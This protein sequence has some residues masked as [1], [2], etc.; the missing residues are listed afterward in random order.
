MKRLE[1]F[2][3]EY[4]R[5]YADT[6]SREREHAYRTALENLVSSLLTDFGDEYKFLQ[7]ARA[8]MKRQRPDFI[9]KKNDNLI[10]ILE[11][12]PPTSGSLLKSMHRNNDQFHRYLKD[13]DNFIVTDGLS[14]K[15][16]LDGNTEPVKRVKLGELQKSM[17]GEERWV[18]DES[19]Q[20]MFMDLLKEFSQGE[21]QGIKDQIEFVIALARVAR[22]I[23]EIILSEVDDEEDLA[24]LYEFLKKEL[25]PT[26][27]EHGFSDTYAQVLVHGLLNIRVMN[28]EE[29]VFDL[30]AAEYLS[31]NLDDGLLQ[32]LIRN[33]LNLGHPELKILLDDYTEL[34]KNS[35]V[36]S[37]MNL[38]DDPTQDATLHFYETFL[39]YYDP[40]MRKARGVFY[41]PLPAV[42]CIV[43][44]VDEMMEVKLGIKGGLVNS[45]DAPLRIIDPATGT[46]T[47]FNQVFEYVYQ[48]LSDQNNLYS[49]KE[50]F[51][52][53]SGEMV[54]FEIMISSYIIAQ[55][56]LSATIRSKL[57]SSG[58]SVKKVESPE[59]LLTNSLE[60]QDL[61][62]RDG[63][64]AL[65]KEIVMQATR[66]NEVKNLTDDEMTTL[67]IGNPPYSAH[68]TNNSE[69]AMQVIE[70][71]K[72]EPESDARLKERNLQPLNDDYVKFMGLSKELISQS[73][74]GMNAFVISNGFLDNITFR[75]MRYDLLDFYNEIY[76][77][78]LH[79]NSRKGE[80]APDGGVDEN[81]FEIMTGVCVFIGIRFDEENRSKSLAK[82]YIKDV[83][84][85]KDHKFEVLNNT[86]ILEEIESGEFKEIQLASPNYFLTT[87]EYEDDY[88]EFTPLNEL[89]KEGSSGITTHRDNIVYGFT[90]KEVETNITNLLT[91]KKT[92]EEVRREFFGESSRG[93]YLPGDSESWELEK[94]REETAFNKERIEL[95]D[96]R[97]FDSRYLYYDSSLIDRDRKEIMKNFRESNTALLFRRGL[98]NDSMLTLFSTDKI[99]DSGVISGRGYVFPL[100][101]YV[102]PEADSLFAEEESEPSKIENFN[103]E[104]KAELLS[105]LSDEFKDE[106]IP[107]EIL[108]YIYGRLNNPAFIERFR[109]ELKVDFPRVPQP[110]SDEI[111]K[112]FAKIGE[113]LVKLHLL[114]SVDEGSEESVCIAEVLKNDL[115]TITVDRPK[116]VNYIG[117]DLKDAPNG[118]IFFGRE[119]VFGGIPEEVWEY[120]I[121]SLK[122]VQSYLKY[123]RGRVLSASEITNFRKMIISLNETIRLQEELSQIESEY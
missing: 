88:M 47:F 67:M 73:K 27:T 1:K 11:H 23:H 54:G 44:N 81:I 34:L 49:L 8:H 60:N 24:G 121:G 13:S 7:E 33:T 66:S 89:F 83:Y 119:A 14:W 100:Y 63:L 64:F 102:E 58:F 109:E 12:K 32:R 17:T 46:G 106:I 26:M 45:D 74:Q 52:E 40:E 95:S 122:P 29:E 80:T 68:S 6:D 101:L 21:V 10:G 15:L 62:Q 19:S 99:A 36:E 108:H 107:E 123:R 86:N 18:F 90:E 114:E 85:T 51:D 31:R 57:K 22:R 4:N 93:R 72:K 28:L 30:R 71:F 39:Q 35:D 56:K 25:I 117:E 59:I 115:T 84:G 53:L 110:E 116:F 103:P 16:Y 77:I 97:A 104:K 42:D 50:V 5:V 75:G 65:Q 79:G 9:L 94:A 87:T 70:A 37:L 98:T 41:T 120:T 91:L 43:R 112:K 105:N 78:D 118:E 111:F 76:V 113:E 82:V 55:M 61:S 2:F 38:D 20:T 3:E 69:Y 92:S 48:K 96:Y